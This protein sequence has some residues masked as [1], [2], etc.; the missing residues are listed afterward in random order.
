M[1]NEITPFENKAIRRVWHDEQ[2]YFSVIDVIAV[3][4]DSPIPRNYWNILKKR[5]PQL[6]TNC[7]QLKLK[8]SDGKNYKT[9]CAHTEGVLRIVMSV[10]S[11]KAEPLKLWL[12]EQGKRTIDELN[13]PEL[14][15]ERQAEYYRLKGYPEEWIAQRMKNIEIRK[16]LTDEWQKRGVEKDKEFS[17]LTATIAKNT[18]GLTPAE[19]AKLKDLEKENLRDHMSNLELLLT[20]LGEEVTRTIAVNSDAKGFTENHEAAQ[21]GG[22]AGRIALKGV[23]KQTGQKVVS[24]DNFK[25]LKGSKTGEIDKNSQSKD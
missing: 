6:H 18:F 8:S 22:E 17:I 11:P 19:H 23:E 24:K 25:H 21:K 15:T 14:L 9:D 3:L 7:M 2:W 5:E 20:S 13:N 4:T 12:A 1:S 16:E 10:P